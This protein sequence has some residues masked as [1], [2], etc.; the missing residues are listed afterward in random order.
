ML[1]F[2][3][4]LYIAIIFFLIVLQTTVFEQFKIAG[5]KPNLVLVFVVSVALLSGNIEGAITGF[6]AG[7]ALDL[8]GGK[9]I[10]LYS[11]LSMY[12]GFICGSLNKRI[13]RENILVII[14]FTFI[15]SIFYEFLVYFVNTINTISFYGNFESSFL[16][17]LLRV[18]LPEAFYNSII[19]IPIHAAMSKISQK[20]R[21]T[22]HP[23]GKY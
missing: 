23:A 15:A 5:V 22:P 4:P 3:L 18:I 13:Y 10:G 2:K 8:S 19:A 17:P 1:K 20:I 7:F 6:F 21:N 11:L 16:R 9:I 14:F 12:A